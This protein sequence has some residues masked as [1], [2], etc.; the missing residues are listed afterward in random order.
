MNEELSEPEQVR[1]IFEVIYDI[2]ANPVNWE[3]LF[4]NFLAGLVVLAVTYWGV[5]KYIDWRKEPARKKLFK[6]LVRET[7]FIS[8]ACERLV[9]Y[10][11]DDVDLDA[12]VLNDRFNVNLGWSYMSTI[13]FNE[14]LAL[15]SGVLDHKK[16]EQLSKI[17]S[18]VSK[19][20]VVL[21][22]LRQY[23]GGFI[24]SL[25]FYAPD[26]PDPLHTQISDAA[27]VSAESFGDP[28]N[29]VVLGQNFYV[30]KGLK[31]RDADREANW[32]IH[33]VVGIHDLLWSAT[34]LCLH[35][36]KFGTTFKYSLDEI[37]MELEKEGLSV[38]RISEQRLRIEETR[39]A[40]V[41]GGLY[42]VQHVIKPATVTPRNIEN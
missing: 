16:V 36:E 13:Q 38:Y 23:D 29:E 5:E 33:F 10:N 21:N 40:I 15:F 7:L 1:T 28:V 12:P 2:V 41:K 18:F 17:S 26:D 35:V 11:N 37:E 8:S 30:I 42:L 4:I 25:E 24:D 9:S 27:R 3:A 19:A 34:Q 20:R 39:K 6:R 14:Q 22:T 31:R 32:R